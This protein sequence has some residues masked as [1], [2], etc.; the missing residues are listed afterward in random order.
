[1]L[2]PEFPA[3]C[4]VRHGPKMGRVSS[5]MSMN[6]GLYMLWPTCSARPR[7]AGDREHQWPRPT[8]GVFRRRNAQRAG[9]SNGWNVK[10][11]QFR[12]QE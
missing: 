5:W 1:M 4:E 8:L 3:V 6:D 12:N 7:V 9:N 2:N 11:R 10:I